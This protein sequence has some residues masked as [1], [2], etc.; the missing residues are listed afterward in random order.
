M[1]AGTAEL[2]LE[3]KKLRK[4][5]GMQSPALEN[6]IGP[7]LRKACGAHPDDPPGTVREQ[8]TDR[9]ETLADSLP[10][11]LSTIVK[12]ALAL[13]PDTTGQFLHERIAWLAA[14]QERDIR[15]IRRRIDDGLAM[16]AEAA[17]ADRSPRHSTG[18]EHDWHVQQFEAVLRLDLP[19]PTSFERR[20]VV[21][22]RDG[23]DE[24]VILYTVPRAPAD[25]RPNH[26]VQVDLHYGARLVAQERMTDSLFRFVLRLP[27][28]LR[29]GTSHEYFMIVRLP[30][31]QPMRPHYLYVPERVCD[32]FDL[33]IRFPE[34]QVPAAV[35]Y[36]RAAFH[37][38]IDD[39]PPHPQLV[40]VDG[41][42]EVH[43]QFDDLKPRL[44]YGLRWTLP[45][46]T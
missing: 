13:R 32:R 15:T 38:A 46:G 28:A 30:E 43:V 44:G 36:V 31:A 12:V 41:V 34:D 10:S 17:T 16:L 9:L 11:D 25:T 24:L 3:L 5:R 45:A 7:E 14:Q 23:L 8:L 42:H 29:R 6:M 18:D 39:G 1:A 4:G 19:A 37:R 22:D 21:A 2:L 35:E 40:P 27:Q 26:D 33:R 20:T